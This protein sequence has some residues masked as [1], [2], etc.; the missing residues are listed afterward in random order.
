MFSQQK[1]D[2]VFLSKI[3]YYVIFCEN[4]R[5]CYFPG[6]FKISQSEAHFVQQITALGTPARQGVKDGFFRYSTKFFVVK[7]VPR[8]NSR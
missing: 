4:T 1:F 6:H 7:L 8:V 5:L 3:K 2:Y